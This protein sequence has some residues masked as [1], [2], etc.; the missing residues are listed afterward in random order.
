MRVHIK[1][2]RDGRPTLTCIRADGS[3]TW[4]RVHPF[5]PLHDLTHYA[6][7]SV[8]GLNQPATHAPPRAP[9]EAADLAAVRALR[10]ELAA[11]WM[12]LGPGETL[13]LVFPAG[14]A[15]RP[16]QGPASCGNAANSA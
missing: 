9:L 15:A 3:R 4:S 13:E 8:L 7:E 2:G 10:S 5:F 14:A 11:R 1:K 16:V 12:T 6:V